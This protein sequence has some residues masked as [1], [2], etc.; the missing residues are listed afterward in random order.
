MFNKREAVKNNYAALKELFAY[1][2]SKLKNEGYQVDKSLLENYIGFGGIPEI[3]LDP[4]NLNSWSKTQ[5]AVHYEIKAI[6]DLIKDFVDGDVERYK[7]IISSIRS[8]QLTSFYTESSLIN[9]SI[10]PL[11]QL[12]SSNPRILDPASGMGA[13]IRVFKDVFPN[14]DIGAVEKEGIVGTIN[15]ILNDIPVYRKGGYQDINLELASFDLIATNTPFGNY[16]AFDKSLVK[17]D[18][19]VKSSFSQIHSFY[20]A[21]SIELLKPGGVIS[22]ITSTG[23]M[24]SL[25][26]TD[27]RKFV[28]ENCHVVDAYRLP[29]FA[30]LENAGTSVSSDLIVLRKRE[31]KLADYLM[32]SVNELSFVDSSGFLDGKQINRFYELNTNNVLGQWEEVFLHNRKQFVIGRSDQ[33][34]TVTQLSDFIQENLQANVI[35]HLSDFPKKDIV[36]VLDLFSSMG[37]VS[38]IDNKDSVVLKSDSPSKKPEFL[39]L[40]KTDLGNRGLGELFVFNN[41]AGVITLDGGSIVL[42][43]S[44]KLI[45]SGLKEI[46]LLNSIKDAYDVGNVVVLNAKYD[47]Y[48]VLF[49]PIHDS[50]IVSLDALSFKL[51]ALENFDG[52]GYVKSDHFKGYSETKTNIVTIEDALLY[53]FNEVGRTDVGVMASVLNLEYNDVLEQGIEKGVLFYEPVFP[54]GFD[55]VGVRKSDYLNLEVRVVSRSEFVSGP[56]G[57]K[58]EFYD[59]HLKHDANKEFKPFLNNLIA[60]ELL[61][62]YAPTR[63]SLIDINPSLGEFWIDESI[64][65]DFVKDVL[66][67]RNAEVKFLKSSNEW[68]VVC[69]DISPRIY[70]ELSVPCKSGRTK[71]PVDILEYALNKAQV[72]ITYSV[73]EKKYTDFDAIELVNANIQN[74]SERFRSY[75]FAHSDYAPHCENKYNALFNR[76]V[77][78]SFDG[79]ELSL[80][81]FNKN[82]FVPRSHQHEATWQL[83]QNLGGLCDHKVGAG[84]SLVIAMSAQELKRIGKVNKSMAICLKA[85]VEAIYEDYMKAYPGARV[86]RPSAKDFEPKNRKELFYRIANNDWDCVII[87]HEQFMSIPQSPYIQQNVIEEELRNVELDLLEITKDGNASIG[88]QKGLEKRKLNLEARLDELLFSMKKDIDVMS[89]DKMGVDYL[90]VDESHY[91]KNLGF[92]TRHDRLAGLGDPKGSQKAM[93]LLFACRTLQAYHG[94][95]KGIAFFTGTSI[96]NSIVE[97]YGTFKYLAPDELDARSISNFDS[98]IGVFAE[99]SSD[100]ELSVTNE[101]KMKTRLRTFVKVPELVSMYQKL[102]NVVNDSNFTVDHPKLNNIPITIPA[103]EEQEW[104]S[105]ELIEAVKTEDFSFV[106][107][108]YSDNQ[109]SA[110]M[111]LA[112]TLSAKAAIDMRMVY[113]TA[114]INSG[115]KLGTLSE[116][117]LEEY[118]D[119]SEYKGTQLVFCDLGTPS[120]EGFNVYAAAREVLVGLGIPENEIAFVSDYNSDKK[121]QLLQDKVNSGKIRVVFGSTKQ[122]GVGWNLQERIIALHHV[123]CPWRPAD[124]EQREGRGSR[125][126]N[127]AAKLYRNNLVNNY[128]YATEKSLDGY[129]YFLVDLKRKFINQIKEGRLDVRVLKEE[130]GE[131]MSMVSFIANI[132]GNKDVLRLAKLDKEL[133]LYIRKERVVKNDY[134][135]TESNIKKNEKVINSNEKF[136]DFLNEDHYLRDSVIKRIDLGQDE[137]GKRKVKF[138]CVVNV[139]G[140]GDFSEFKEA[141]DAIIEKF[142]DLKQQVESGFGST[143]SRYPL[144]S[145]G[146]FSMEISF[147]KDFDGKLIHDVVVL[148]RSINGGIHYSSGGKQISPVPGVTGRYIVDALN[149]I[150]TLKES[151]INSISNAKLEIEGLTTKLERLNPREFEQHI[152][153]LQ[154]EKSE[155]VKMLSGH[156]AQENDKANEVS[157]PKQ[158]YGRNM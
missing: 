139:E 52:K 125:Q 79:V 53:S 86:L 155:L 23:I 30:F 87:T 37:Q 31:N 15:T 128:F 50:R 43:S 47:E 41:V 154:T 4:Y 120:S 3:L 131:D 71:K 64:Y 144:A 98:W 124:L 22:F 143:G 69:H 57:Y 142:G 111:L 121:K 107:R 89:F 116:K 100:L 108:A 19:R 62:E 132:S 151:C 16:R 14:S 51:K 148:N 109:L 33:F 27:L 130:E 83:M 61:N 74:I 92:T 134:L 122:M 1:N 156:V 11:K 2:K 157:E 117:I 5:Q 36:E 153:S 58:K 28:V 91:F 88:Q 24:D 114:D 140:H 10:E 102:A 45:A 78:R 80:P 67:N 26:N 76:D 126:G 94:A 18:P 90:M 82:L 85:N 55:F 104:F 39:V 146:N 6:H 7:S 95:D 110:K 106:G 13:Y 141:G 145:I 42:D 105:K 97:L 68:S 56:V 96:S 152:K 123:D 29:N 137:E 149:K 138:E 65:S 75:L 34:T 35:K 101:V 150:E 99:A 103:S 136:L 60:R 112:T 59:F 81:G 158:S 49:G 77:A 115:S 133:E 118:K 93:N 113:D 119:S 12:V 135:L 46:E 66:D 48:R 72:L 25:N 147:N 40:A 73:D 9:A 127:K 17:S 129:K 63:L 20:F 38:S 8:S 70:Q 44:N 32:A 54:K 21:K 84:K